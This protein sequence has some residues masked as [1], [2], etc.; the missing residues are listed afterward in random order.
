METVKRHHLNNHP[1]HDRSHD[2]SQDRGNFTYDRVTQSLKEET[3]MSR[4][5]ERKLTQTSKSFNFSQLKTE[6]IR[7]GTILSGGSELDSIGTF[8][9]KKN[10]RNNSS[11]EL[12]ARRLSNN[13]YNSYLYD[14]RPD[15]RNQFDQRPTSQQDR[16]TVRPPYPRKQI[17]KSS[18][19]SHTDCHEAMKTTQRS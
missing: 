1:S 19:H 8:F 17:D 7:P 4:E 12:S 10:S 18:G 15:L 11:R 14:Q 9:E 5:E 2:R 3:L 13:D 16:Q 6:T